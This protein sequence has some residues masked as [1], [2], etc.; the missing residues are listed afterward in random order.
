MRQNLNLHRNY[1]LNPVY[2]FFTG[3]A[4]QRISRRSLDLSLPEGLLKYVLIFRSKD[5]MV[6]TDAL[7]RPKPAATRAL[8]YGRV[9]PPLW[10]SVRY[11]IMLQ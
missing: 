3:T 11:P 10:S 4:I 5:E 2:H 7:I 8:W 1:L 6:S 9:F